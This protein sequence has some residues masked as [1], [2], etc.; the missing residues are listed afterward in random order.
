LWNQV[1]NPG[2]AATLT[3]QNSRRLFNNQRNRF[4]RAVRRDPAALQVIRNMGGTFPEARNGGTLSPN[5]SSVPEIN[6]PN[7]VRLRISLDHAVERQ[8]R[9]AWR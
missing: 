7:G 9:R 4:W 2:E 1:A 5:A 6:L 3:A 8:T